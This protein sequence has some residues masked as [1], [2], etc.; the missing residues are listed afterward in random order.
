MRNLFFFTMQSPDNSSKSVDNVVE[1]EHLDD[2]KENKDS[3][4]SL[5]NSKIQDDRK[6]RIDA[7]VDALYD[8]DEN[9][10]DKER[11][12]REKDKLFLRRKL[13]SSE[14]HVNFRDFRIIFQVII[15]T[16]IAFAIYKYAVH[17]GFFNSKK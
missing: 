16:L 14:S 15:F 17:L 6:N 1:D 8:D 5:A 4:K 2:V 13:E 7:V 10:T 11:K 9:I 12:Q 3:F